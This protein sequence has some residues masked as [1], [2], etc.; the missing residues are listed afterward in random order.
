MMD[1]GKSGPAK[2]AGKPTNK[3]ER[4]ATEPVEPRARAEG[5]AGQQST[6]Q[7]LHQPIADHGK[8]LGQVVK[9]YFNY[10]AVPTN[11]QALAIF[12][13]FVTELWR[14]TV[15]RRSQKDAMTWERITRLGNDWLPKPR[16]LHPW[17]HQRFAVNYPRQEPYASIG[18][19]RICAGRAQQW[20]S[21]PRSVTAFPF[22]RLQSERL[23]CQS[24]FEFEFCSPCRSRMI[25]GIQPAEAI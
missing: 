23:S 4:S 16:V 7:A 19:V 6:R 10:H 18:L 20:A 8:W 21:L 25:V 15:R 3:A 9:G 12:R 13:F 22:G 14:R 24:V 17:P 1:A 2:V 11:S 5:N